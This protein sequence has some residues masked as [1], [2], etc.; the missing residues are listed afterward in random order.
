[1]YI[2]ISAYTILTAL[3]FQEGRVLILC[4]RREDSQN[5]ICYV[6]D[7]VGETA[8]EQKEYWPNTQPLILDL[9][10]GKSVILSVSLPIPGELSKS[11]KL[12]PT[13]QQWCGDLGKKAG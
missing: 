13:K 12:S 7:S 1:M 2:H 8:T 11:Y 10:F 5:Q 9:F 6:L 4:Y 3:G